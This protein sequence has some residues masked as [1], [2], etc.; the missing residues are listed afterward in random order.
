MLKPLK[1]LT[2]I[3]A[4]LRRGA[5]GAPKA[6]GGLRQTNDEK[7][8]HIRDHPEQHYH[9]FGGLTACCTVD[10]A[11]V[12]QLMDAHP[13]LGSNGG[14]KCDVLVTEVGPGDFLCDVMIQDGRERWHEGSLKEAIRSVID[15]AKVLNGTVIGVDGVSVRLR[16]ATG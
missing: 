4:A 15:A 10:G 3:V 8:K 9:D 6:V 11:L 16:P 5:R 2:G 13:S 14:Q 7:L 12:L 1:A